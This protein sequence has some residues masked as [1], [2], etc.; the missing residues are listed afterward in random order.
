MTWKLLIAFMIDLQC[1][2]YN[3]VNK[4]ILFIV[5]FI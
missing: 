2:F 1:C 4:F 3:L 5:V